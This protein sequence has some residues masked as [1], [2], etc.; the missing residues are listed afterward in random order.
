MLRAITHKV[1]SRIAD[2]ELTF[3]DRA[4][5]DLEKAERQ[6]ALYSAALE[7]LGVA[8]T[9][10]SEND[11]YPDACFVEDTAVVVDE[12]AV[13]CS[14][15]VASRRG[16]TPLIERELSRHREIAR[17]SLPATIE[18]GDVLRVGKKVFV[19]RSTRTNDQGIAE[20][21]RLLSPL[22]Y[23]VVP[24]LTKQSLHLKSV[25]TAIDDQTLIVNPN[26]IGLDP[27]G[28]FNLVHTPA[29]E[30]WAGN[31]VRVGNSVCVQAGFPR[32]VETVKRAAERV[33]VVDTS[34]LGKAEG[35]LTCLSIIFDAAV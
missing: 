12:L 15:G 29:D 13:M 8:I 16:E 26:W 7:K 24:V 19:G 4:S 2:C 3:I 31:V 34:E 32:T 21:A 5:I 28:G 9:R 6:H 1:S 18:G 20:L 30:P 22:G 11:S 23:T 33:E 35:A 27:F 17:V 25:C 14:M 10:L